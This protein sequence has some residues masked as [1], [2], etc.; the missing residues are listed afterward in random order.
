MPLIFC[1]L[2]GEMTSSEISEG[3]ALIQIGLSLAPDTTFTATIGH[4]PGSYTADPKAMAVHGITEAAIAA[5]PSAAVVDAQARRWLLAHGASTAKKLVIPVGFNVGAFDMPF[6][7]ATLPG[8][9]R[10]LSRRTVDLNAVCFAMDGMPY[11]GSTPRWTGWKRLAKRAAAQ[12]L[13]DVGVDA[14]WH[15][16]GYDAAAALVAF[17][18]LKRIIRD[19]MHTMPE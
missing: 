2:D 3:G 8:T 14:A 13:A 10:L 12:T 15:D 11:E 9:Y 16:A 5:A 1:G 17:E 19:R 18:W 4:R 7:K 6:V